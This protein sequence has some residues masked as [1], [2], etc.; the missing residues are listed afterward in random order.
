[1]AYDPET[2]IL[3]LSFTRD[4]GEHA[5][6]MLEMGRRMTTSA[7]PISAWTGFGL[8]IGFGAVVGVVM[9]IH[10]R[11]V[12]PMLAGSSEIA[13]LGMVALQ[14]LP[15]LLLVAALYAILHQRTI[16]RRRT[17]LVSRLER[18]LV[19]DVDIFSKGLTSSSGQVTID[20]DWAAVTDIVVNGNRIEIECESFA[21]YLP[22]RAFT[23][24]AAFAEA[25]RD[26]RKLWREAVKHDRDSRM[27]AA[28]LD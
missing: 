2:R 18:N 3:S 8:A 5:D 13:P 10:R 28:G 20:I 9:E 19:I 4:P 27:L 15:L 17:A 24:R 16:R 26:L 7:D 22:E 12:L 23:N 6:A 1:M 25:A 21:T 11:F 14:L